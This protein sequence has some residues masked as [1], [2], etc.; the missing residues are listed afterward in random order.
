MQEAARLSSRRH[1]VRRRAAFI[2]PNDDILSI[3]TTPLIM[4]ACVR[5]RVGAHVSN[6]VALSSMLHMLGT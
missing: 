2:R 3:E 6:V 4:I 5:V 1:S